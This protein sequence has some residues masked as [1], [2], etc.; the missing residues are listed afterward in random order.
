MAAGLG[1]KN[2]MYLDTL[3]FANTL[4]EDLTFFFFLTEQL[5]RETNYD[6]I[7]KGLDLLLHVSFQLRRK[8][9]QANEM[10]L[11]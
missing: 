11:V 3:S 10:R 4:F 9:I 5:L 7:F 2:P 1:I 6:F 8:A